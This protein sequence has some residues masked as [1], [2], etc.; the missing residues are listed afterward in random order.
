MERKVYLRQILLPGSWKCDSHFEWWEGLICGEGGAGKLPRGG[1]LF[2]DWAP[3]QP[4][5][6]ELAELAELAGFVLELVL[7]FRIATSVFK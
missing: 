1:W 5:A 6:L 2:C 7:D 4:L 3:L